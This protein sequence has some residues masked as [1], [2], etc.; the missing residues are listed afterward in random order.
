MKKIIENHVKFFNFG[1]DKH[2][3]FLFQHIN[4]MVLFYVFMYLFFKKLSEL[5]FNMKYLS[6]IDMNIVLDFSILIVLTSIFGYFSLYYR[7]KISNKYHEQQ[8]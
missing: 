1:I 8:K 3:Y 4:C 7:K 2:P 6:N 5:E